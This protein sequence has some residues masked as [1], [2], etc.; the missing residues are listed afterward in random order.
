MTCRPDR[1]GPSQACCPPIHKFPEGGTIRSTSTAGWPAPPAVPTC[2]AGSAGRL[3]VVSEPGAGGGDFGGPVPSVSWAGMRSSSGED[4]GVNRLAGKAM[5]S[6]W[7]GRS[8]LY[9]S[10][11]A[12]SAACSASMFANGPWTSSSSR[13][14][15][16][17]RRSIFPVVVREW[18]LV[19]RWAM[20]FS[21]ADL[22]EQHFDRYAGLVE[23][24]GE[25]LAVVGQ[26]FLGHS[27]DAHRIHER[28]AHRAGGRPH[29]R[30]GDHAEPGLVTDPG[31]DLDFGAVSEKGTGGHIQLP[32]VNRGAAFPTPVILAPAVPRRRLDQAVPNQSAIHAGTGYLAA[33]A[34]HLEYQPAR[35][36]ED[37]RGATHRSAPR[38]RRGC[39]TDGDGPG[40]CG[41]PAP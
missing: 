33:T 1:T 28:Q 10:R 17:C 34:A 12:S 29:D 38:L 6:D 26:D 4:V 2:G 9:S 30:F 27:V 35:P 21:R 40:G 20:P 14:R 37:G 22:V 36:T 24:P 23:P 5:P 11:Q 3:G 13:W 19:S 18:I 31:R 7:C 39:A 15:L 32:Q 25:H 16:W 41:P 8:V